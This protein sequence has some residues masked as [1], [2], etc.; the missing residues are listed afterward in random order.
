MKLEKQVVSLELA[1]QLEKLGVEQ[2]SLFYWVETYWENCKYKHYIPEDRLEKS[3]WQLRYKDD[4]DY[5]VGEEPV[6]RRYS[7]PTVAELGEMLPNPLIIK[8]KGEMDKYL[9]FGSEHVGCEWECGSEKMLD[10][11]FVDKTEANARAKMLI[12]LIE[13]KLI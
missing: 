8:E 6:K 10:H 13:N 7:A 11:T 9:Y 4:A 12:Y 1:K 3:I 5:Q 2:E